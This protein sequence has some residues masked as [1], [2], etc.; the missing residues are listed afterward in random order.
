M[1]HITIKYCPECGKPMRRIR[2][3][4]GDFYGCTGYPTCKHRE[5]CVEEECCDLQEEQEDNDE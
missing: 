2:G 3:K 5:G 1:K 4:C